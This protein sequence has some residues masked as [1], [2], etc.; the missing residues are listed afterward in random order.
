MIVWRIANA[1]HAALD[2]LGGLYVPGRW[3]NS[4]RP[5]IYAADSSALSMLEV[6]VHLDLIVAQL[7]RFVML[8][9]EVPNGVSVQTSDSDPQNET[10]ARSVGD[11]WLA[12]R[13]TALMQVQSALAPEG[14]NYLINPLHPDAGQIAII[15][16]A[17]F[18]F[19]ARLSRQ[20]FHPTRQISPSSGTPSA[21]YGPPSPL[22]RSI[23]PVRL[24]CG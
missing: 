19:D 1:N 22:A 9:I 16:Q 6:R 15:A 20:D 24:S 23:L 11:L 7:P 21:P 14:S 3:H 13:T 8:K 10:L 5:I 17:Q 4:G 2:G 12:G 18:A